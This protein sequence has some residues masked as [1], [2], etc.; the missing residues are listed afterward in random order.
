M[1]TSHLY[2]I[3]YNF[4]AEAKVK[5][6]CEGHKNLLKFLSLTI[7]SFFKAG[8]SFQILWPSHDII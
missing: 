1:V 3:Y 4:A 6:F 8:Y 5:I 2:D 7:L